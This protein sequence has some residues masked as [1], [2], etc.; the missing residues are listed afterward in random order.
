MAKNLFLTINSQVVG[1]LATIPD[2]KDFSI[3]GIDYEYVEI[4]TPNFYTTYESMLESRP[5]IKGDKKELEYLKYFMSLPYV[6]TIEK[7]KQ[8][9]VRVRVV[10]LTHKVIHVA[11][12]FTLN[13]K[14]KLSFNSTMDDGEAFAQTTIQFVGKILT[15]L[16]KPTTVKEISVVK[17]KRKK[18]GKHKSRKPNV[19]YVY[20]T[21][22]KVVNISP[23]KTS[24]NTYKEREWNKEEWARRGHYRVYRDKNTGE[25]K[26]RVWI[27][28]T[29]CKAHGK[30]KENQ[31]VKITRLD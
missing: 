23:E 19:Q 4:T 7:M 8:G 29:T 5:Q 28:S 27:N 12:D 26:K 11:V 2:S 31:H 25:I 1:Q 13:S 9:D 17:E 22:C 10:V 16:D 24:R 30:I 20:K 6:V 18:S 15:Y 14:N 21:V 3:R